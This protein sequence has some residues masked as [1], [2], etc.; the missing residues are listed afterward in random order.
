M[1]K[2]RFVLS[3]AAS[4]LTWIVRVTKIRKIRYRNA[5]D[6][7]REYSG[8]FARFPRLERKL[9][10]DTTSNYSGQ[11]LMRDTGNACLAFSN[12]DPGIA[13]AR[14]STCACLGTDSSIVC[15]PGTQRCN[16]LLGSTPTPPT[17]HDT[18]GLS[19]SLRHFRRYY[20]K[21]K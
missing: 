12:G 10:R 5:R 20:S 17:F 14:L 18:S 13:S 3:W 7:N 6:C 1:K 11:R 4:I 19:F 21:I 8:S 2:L 15:L 9:L 16:I